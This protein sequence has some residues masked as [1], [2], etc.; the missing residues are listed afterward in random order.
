MCVCVCV[1]K[2]HPPG[3]PNVTFTDNDTV[4]DWH[5]GSPCSVLLTAFDYEVQTQNSDP[6]TKAS[7]LHVAG[8]DILRNGAQWRQSVAPPS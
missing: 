8:V 1:V 4:I 7:V 6:T 2:M 3:L 5:P